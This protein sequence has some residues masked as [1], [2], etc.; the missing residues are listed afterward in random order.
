[1]VRHNLRRFG[2]VVGAA[3]VMLV[4]TALPAAAHVTVN[5]KEANQ[6]GFAKLAFRV[7][8][9]RDKA[10][11]KLEVAFPDKDAI[12]NVSYK[13][14]PGWKV[15]VTKKKLDKPIKV[16]G[17]D[18][19]EAVDRV[20]WT[21]DSAATAIQPGQFQEFEVSVGPLPE[22]D[23]LVFKALQTYDGGEVVRWIDE[24]TGSEEPEHPAPVLKLVKAADGDH[25]DDDDAPVS[26]GDAAASGEEHDDEDGPSSIAIGAL[27]A[28]LAGLVLGA[29]A[30]VRTR[31]AA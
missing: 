26:D 6:G 8:N 21:A 18:V 20:T 31:K 10:T 30:L 19:S 17:E 4:A 7:P 13:P 27:I 3:T 22:V 16:H 9:E 1:M 15:A 29:V 25:H 12:A 2:A 28:G 23:Q 11:T 5:P 14:L 24:T